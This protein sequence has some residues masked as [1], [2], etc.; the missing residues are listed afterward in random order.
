[1]TFEELLAENERLKKENEALKNIDKDDFF[2]LSGD[3]LCTFFHNRFLQV[4]PSFISSLGYSR[5]YILSQD[6]DTFL[7]PDDIELTHQTIANFTQQE[8]QISL[9][10]RYRCSNGNYITIFWRFYVKK[11]GV[12]YGVGR[13][14]TQQ[15]E[16]EKAVNQSEQL[17]KAIFN[18]NSYVFVVYDK[19]FRPI[20]VNESAKRATHFLYGKDIAKQENVLDVLPNETKE[21]M[22]HN[23][24]AVLNGETIKYERKVKHRFSSDDLWYDVTMTP[25]YLD[26][27][28]VGVCY[29]AND[30]TNHKQIES[31]IKELLEQEKDLTEQLKVQ[32]EELWQNVEE[33]RS[34]KDYLELSEN[35]ARKAEKEAI[36]NKERLEHI[37]NN[38]DHHFFWVID[39]K[40][41]EIVLLSQGFEKILDYSVKEVGDIAHNLVEFIHP[42]DLDRAM[43]VYKLLNQGIAQDIELRFKTATGEIKWLKSQ[44]KVYW[45]GDKIDRLEGIMTDI[46]SSKNAEIALRNT[47]KKLQKTQQEL[48]YKNQELDTFVYRASHDIRGPIA[49]MLG[50]CNLLQ[51]GNFDEET[52]TYINLLVQRTKRLDSILR[53]LTELIKIKD[54]EIQKQVV[55]FDTIINHVRLTLADL[56]NY[57]FIDWNIQIGESVKDIESDPNLLQIVLQHLTENSI[58]FARIPR[59]SPYLAIRV[60]VNRE[61]TLLKIEVED[62]GCGIAEESLPKIYNMFYRGVENSTG[63]GLGLYI[64]KNAIDKLGGK[65]EVKT[66]FGLGTTFEITIPIT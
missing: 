13:D 18:S 41:Q 5:E 22:L 17:L 38:L 42:D 33:M 23:S 2:S 29:A 34:M 64:L 45:Q 11:T 32:N 7:H 58:N 19:N 21:D 37:F 40:T 15:S 43:H 44:S 28:V 51:M 54:V 65:I 6:I 9:Q 60:T 56:P 63:S 49:S 46:T 62:N 12:A 36:L 30:I 1:M 48:E 26:R 47:I 50:L 31:R 10:N 20:K 27:Q 66:V 57:P 53:E 59:N 35:N 24:L 14:I 52:K 4:N 55:N 3:F 8:G 25:L 16:L 61:E 39:H